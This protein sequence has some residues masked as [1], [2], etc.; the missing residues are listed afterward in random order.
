[1]MTSSSLK[2]LGNTTR[3]VFGNP[4]DFLGI[5]GPRDGNN[6]IVMTQSFVHRTHLDVFQ[7]VYYPTTFKLVLR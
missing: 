5:A 3:L 2:L 1:M 6:D 7:G 4:I